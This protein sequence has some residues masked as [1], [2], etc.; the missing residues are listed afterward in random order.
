[1]KC[2][3]MNLEE[4]VLEPC[5]IIMP[6]GS[7]C[8]MKPVFHDSSFQ[9]DRYYGCTHGL[10][11]CQIGVQGDRDGAN[12]NAMA[13]PL[14]RLR[15]EFEKGATMNPEEVERRKIPARDVAHAGDPCIY[16]GAKHDAV[17]I[18]PCRARIDLTEIDVQLD[19]YRLEIE[20][21]HEAIREVRSAN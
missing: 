20:K 6:D 17:P 4:P 2:I 16:C 12:W 9:P 18:G 15:E 13:A 1:M 11:G 21:L 7:V 10:R 14:N 5:P 8:G 19:G 3:C